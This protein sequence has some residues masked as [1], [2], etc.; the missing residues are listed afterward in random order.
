MEHDADPVAWWSPPPN[1]RWRPIP[2]PIHGGGSICTPDGTTNPCAFPLSIYLTATVDFVVLQSY[3][4]DVLVV[5]SR[6][7][8]SSFFVVVI[9]CFLVFQLLHPNVVI[10]LLS[11]RCCS[12]FQL[13]QSH[14]AVGVSCCCSSLFGVV[15]ITCSWCFNWFNLFVEALCSVLLHNIFMVFQLV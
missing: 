1:R 10:V 14:V 15:A 5:Y 9:I 11:L 2:H 7:F 3:I 6:C 4:R 13:L 12:M 8:S